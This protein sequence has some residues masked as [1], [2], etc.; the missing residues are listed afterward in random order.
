MSTENNDDVRVGHVK[1]SRLRTGWATIRHQ[2]AV[3]RS[4]WFLVGQTC[5][6]ALVI[7]AAWI[8]WLGPWIA[9]NIEYSW[10]R[11]SHWLPLPVAFGYVTM[12]GRMRYL[13]LMKAHATVKNLPETTSNAERVRLTAVRDR[14]RA[15]Y[16]LIGEVFAAMS[17]FG[18]AFSLTAAYNSFDTRFLQPTPAAIEADLKRVQELTEKTC[19]IGV[20]ADICT[21]RPTVGEMIAS[22]KRETGAIER[23][24]A[25]SEALDR[26][27]PMLDVIQG[28]GRVELARLFDEIDAAFPDDAWFSLLQMSSASLLILSVAIAVGFKLAVASYEYQT[29]PKPASA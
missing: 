22:I 24:E 3:D 29:T 13:S 28:D 18:A 8:F 20:Q 2:L 7:A 15:L 17:V 10:F 16:K 27:R 12:I 23:H 9:D 19:R 14:K 21:S 4:V 11:R 26:L 6:M 5:V 25:V 1:E